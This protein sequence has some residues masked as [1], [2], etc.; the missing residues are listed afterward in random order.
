VDKKIINVIPMQKP[1]F[2]EL[3][4]QIIR[5]LTDRPQMSQSDIARHIG[6]SQ[7][8]IG[9]HLKK[10]MTHGK[11]RFM[12]GVNIQDLPDVEVV[13]VELKAKNPDKYLESAGKC[14]LV[15]NAFSNFGEFNILLYMVFFQIRDF[16]KVIE[17]M[18]YKSGEIK[19]VKWERAPKM[20]KPWVI[21]FDF[22]GL[23]LEDP[24]AMCKKCGLC[25]LQP[26][27]D[28]QTEKQ[29]SM[30]P[31]HSVSIHTMEPAI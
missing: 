26:E 13:K 17:H 7:P 4:T 31:M 12:F 5:M 22:L 16:D 3:D 14:P 18:F 6:I 10:I 29:E 8:S 15:I 20:A 30:V 28:Q 23:D 25:K 19:A 24:L 1:N 27:I 21:N 2:D 9:A 11:Y